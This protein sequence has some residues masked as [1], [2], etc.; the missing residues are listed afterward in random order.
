[1]SNIKDASYTTSLLKQRTLFANY[2]ILKTAFNYGLINR[3]IFEGGNS[4]GATDNQ[5]IYEIL[6]GA[7][8]TTSAEQA[9]YIAS[10]PNPMP[11]G[12][13]YAFIFD[14]ATGTLL[15]YVGTLPANLVIPT[16]INGQAV[17]SISEGAFSNNGS[18]ETVIFPTGSY[19]AIPNSLFQNCPNLVSVYVDPGITTV[20]NNVFQGCTNLT[21]VTLPDSVSSIGPSTF[22]NTGLITFSVPPTITVL[23][24]Y[25]FAECSS[26]TSVSIPPGLVTIGSNTF[27]ACISLTSITLPNTLESIGTYAFSGSGLVSITLPSLITELTPFVFSYCL[28]LESVALNTADPYTIGNSSFFSC[29]GLTSIS[30]T[31]NIISIGPSA[32]QGCISLNLNLSQ[33]TGLTT[34][35]N[36]AFSSSGL[37]SIALPLLVTVLSEGV[38]LG[39]QNLT[40]VG[41][42]SGLTTIQN[43]AFSFCPN[44]LTLTIPASVTTIESI[45]FYGSGTGTLFFNTN[46]PTLSLAADTF[47]GIVNPDIIYIPVGGNNAAWTAAV[48]AAGWQ[49]TVVNQPLVFEYLIN[50]TTGIVNGFLGPIPSTITLPTQVSSITVTGFIDNLFYSQSAITSVI[51]PTPSAEGFTTLSSGIFDSCVN[52]TT[53]TIN[54]GVTEIAALAFR[55]CSALTT[56]SLPTSLTTFGET[57]FASCTSLQSITIPSQITALADNLFKACTSLT[58]INLPA[59]LVTIGVTTF[60][61]CNSLI[62]LDLSSCTSLTYIGNLAFKQCNGLTSIILPD[63]VTYI[64]IGAFLGCVALETIS[65]PASLTSLGTSAFESCV[66]LVTITIP[67]QI[68]ALADNLFKACSSLT[69]VTLPAGLVSIGNFTF[70][71]CTALPSITLP[72]SVLYIGQSAFQGCTLLASLTPLTAL[73]YIGQSAFQDCTSLNLDLSQAIGLT[74]LLPYAFSGCTMLT[75]LNIVGLTGLL[76]LGTGVFDSSGLTVAILP[77]QIIALPDQFFINCTSLASTTLPDSL[78]TIGLQVFQGCTAL[79]YLDIPAGV[80]QIGDSAFASSG[81]VNFNFNNDIPPIFG[82]TVFTGIADQNTIYITIAADNDTWTAAV[83]A[84]GWSG[85]VTNVT[86]GYGYRIDSSG[87]VYATVGT[88]P[89]SITLPTTV[90]TITVTSFSP[91]LFLNNTDI[92]YVTVPTGSFTYLPASMFQGCT[93]LATVTISSSAIITLDPSIFQGCTALISVSGA[94]NVTSIGASAF[95]GCTSLASLTIPSSLTTIGTETLRECT[96]LL[97]IDLSSTSITV[98]SDGLFYGCTSLETVT[99]PAG[100]T[101]IDDSL[102]LGCFYGCTSLTSVANSSG[103]LS[104]LTYIG[105]NAFY[106]CDN[107]TTDTKSLTLNMRTA[108]LVGIGSYTFYVCAYLTTIDLTGS[109]V[110][111]TG[112]N[113]G[114]YAFSGSGLTS[115]TLPAGITQLNNNL[116]QQ[117]LSLTSV[118]LPANLTNISDGV[119]QDCIALVSV[120]ALSNV[121]TIGNSAFQGC[122]ALTSLSGL[123]NVTTI[124][125]S[126][127]LDCN[128]SATGTKSLTLDFSAAGLI[129]IGDSAFQG[130]TYLTTL[131]LTGSVSTLIKI[132]QKAFYTSGLTSIT[133]PAGITILYDNVFG[134]CTSLTSVTLSANLISIF[135]YVFSG[136]T[137]LTSITI[138]S[139]V[140]LIGSYAFRYSGIETITFNSINPPNFGRSVFANMP[141]QQTAYVLSGTVA[142]AW[143][144]ALRNAGWSASILNY[145]F[146][147]SGGIL[148]GYLGTLPATLTVPTVV[149]GVTITGFAASLFRANTNIVNVTIPAGSYTSLSTRMFNNCT[150]LQTVSLSGITRIGQYAFDASPVLKSVTGLDSV[151]YI[152]NYAFNNTAYGRSDLTLDFSS[153]VLTYIGDYAFSYAGATKLDFSSSLLTYIGQFAL[154]YCCIVAAQEQV[155]ALDL[156]KSTGL[157]TIGASAFKTSGISNFIFGITSP[158]AT[159]GANAFAVNSSPFPL[160]IFIPANANTATWTTPL[161]NAGWTGNIYN[162]PSFTISSGIITGYTSTL[163]AGVVVPSVV[164]G[165]TVTGFASGLF[166]SN[167][168]LTNVIFLA[169]TY[170]ALS[171]NM[172]NDCENLRTVSLP[173]GI[174]TIGVTTFQNCYSLININFPS[175]LSTFG[176]GAFQS[177][178]SSYSASLASTAITVLPTYVFYNNYF[179]SLTLPSGLTTIGISAFNTARIDSH[180]LAI[181]ASVTSVGNDAFNNLSCVTVIFQSTTP[182]TFGTNAFK[183]TN[184]TIVHVPANLSSWTTAL[185]AAGYNGNI[186]T[187]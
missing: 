41:L 56:I 150:Y 3:F 50:A 77:P 159:I 185:R 36:Y 134:N 173:S 65:L 161:T 27:L 30:P 149:N 20:G 68:T 167:M 57:V 79:I 142:G 162:V 112:D 114:Q 135:S 144:T 110:S 156:S 155:L 119:F 84:T 172:F 170:T 32:F 101:T 80:N 148:T 136:C 37:T 17:T 94:S 6:Q 48:T 58:S 174:T 182:P 72:D 12:P 22:A 128:N 108:A 97:S 69:D 131:N 107:S 160:G 33:A 125:N 24:D 23:S 71:G 31:Q 165:Q 87:N 14:P 34:I 164:S 86:T 11:P 18:I 163:S 102:Q 25:L 99:V 2:T 139:S 147:Q 54:E 146:T 44:L 10:V 19:T 52:I 76:S 145:K 13:Q 96:S 4:S 88:F 53:V 143:T 152:D 81:I 75:T 111:L 45:A 8:E 16:E 63:S 5:I 124:G 109:S 62:S 35:G 93:S 40:S 181:P 9:T 133:I 28:S 82:N 66:S 85:A 67:S 70:T 171:D 118:T 157:T 137:S 141:N 92:Q 115:I 183:T 123:S 64:G 121:T 90:D 46:T 7:V 47:S 113:I 154:Y 29:T 26:L 175:T 15:G 117:C 100:L 105:T 180:I 178:G 130:C 138:P 158:P 73:T 42:T 61:G 38:F 43:N 106:G 140:T 104:S 21:N 55:G 116:F 91:S 103:N 51:V 187:P 176:I 132:G 78:Q 83:T 39:C 127:F 179:N 59:G 122:T 89:S 151:T 60:G 169:G 98:L 168:T 166:R 1:M 120:S 186:V 49:G 184:V 177:A 126:A 95:K 74:T 129:F 153:S